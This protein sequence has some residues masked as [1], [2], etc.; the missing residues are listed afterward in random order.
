MR[1]VGDALEVLIADQILAHPSDV[2]AQCLGGGGT[3]T[4]M[5]SSIQAI[6]GELPSYPSSFLPTL[7]E[8][9][10][11]LV[12]GASRLIPEEQRGQPGDAVDEP[13]WRHERHH[14]LGDL[15]RAETAPSPRQRGTRRAR[16]PS[17]ESSAGDGSNDSHRRRRLLAVHMH[18]RNM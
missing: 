2:L 4:P 14:G 16:S 15:R 7:Q 13:W 1:A 6:I 5:V 3:N 12:R 17:M 18:E 9:A 11:N 8:A 10:M